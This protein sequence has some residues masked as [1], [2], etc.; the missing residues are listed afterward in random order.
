MF[1]TL[2]LLQKIACIVNKW[3]PLDPSLLF[4]VEFNEK[5]FIEDGKS[6]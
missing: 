5:F 4:L 6:K 3:G 2:R 1:L